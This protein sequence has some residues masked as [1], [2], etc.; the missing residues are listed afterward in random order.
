MIQFFRLN[1]QQND[2]SE[3]FGPN[4]AEGDVRENTIQETE[5]KGF[6]RLCIGMARLLLPI[7]FGYAFDAKRWL[8]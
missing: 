7:P 4:Q 1:V 2:R 6:T 8:W 3:L 5:I